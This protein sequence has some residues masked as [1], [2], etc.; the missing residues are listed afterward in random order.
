MPRRHESERLG[1]YGDRRHFVAV[2][3]VC[4]IRL[5]AA[6]GDGPTTANSPAHP[7]TPNTSQPTT[8]AS[9]PAEDG[10]IYLTGDW[11][12]LRHTLADRGIT[13]AFTLTS[14]GTKNLQGGLNTGSS[15]WRT[16][17]EATAT[18][19]TKALFG[20]DG[21]T[22]F[23]DFQNVQGPNADDKLIG[24]AQ[25]IDGLDGVPGAPHQNRTQLA[26]LWYQQ[27]A[28][29]GLLRLK[30]GKIDA[31]TEFD[32]SPVAQQ[33]LNQSAGSSATLFT[34]PT[35]PDP[36]TGVNLFLKPSDDLQF[37][38]GL[39]DGSMAN[40]VRTG[41]LGPATFFRN[42]D[43][44]FLISELDKTWSLGSEHLPGRIGVGGWYSTNHFTRLNG[45]VADGSGAPYAILDQAV[46]REN[47]GD[48][49]DK[50]GL[51]LFLM[52]GYADPG[53]LLYDRNIG[54]G[55]AWTGPCSAR[56]NDVVG[57]GVQAVHFSADDHPVDPFEVSYET[58]YQA[59][60]TPWFIVKP[61]LQYIQNPGGAGI[62]DA[63]ALTLRI[64]INF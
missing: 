45:G 35:Y 29:D 23:V 20:L 15:T 38:F 8:S 7:M 43:D 24:D 49:Q 53:I 32:N 61:D 19:D 47:P 30:L 33:F 3:L 46:W 56:P 64:Q 9:R 57:V 2:I 17:A 28:F 18:F 51:D 37:G 5:S 54:G 27:I 59:Q 16:M 13:F 11:F 36:A 25:G 34:L 48:D 58:F 12:G 55:I 60:V 4:F 1:G 21:G 10:S 41:E 62:P 63:L 26:Q 6:W 40:G 39:Y 31:S 22:A 14:D 50:R 44:L 42:D 52:Y